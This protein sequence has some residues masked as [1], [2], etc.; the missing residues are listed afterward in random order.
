M[1]DH[2]IEFLAGW[3]NGRAAAYRAV[4][5]STLHPDYTY[6][7]PK[8]SDHVAHDVALLALT[9]PIRMNSVT[10]F[11]I[12]ARPRKGDTVGVVSYARDR[13]N[14]PALQ[15][16]CHVLGRP[17]GAL[18][19]SCDVDFGSSGAPVFVISDTGPEIVSVISAKAE[20]RGRPV[21]VGTGLEDSIFA[22]RQ[23]L[24]QDRSERT[25]HGTRIRRHSVE[26]RPT[27]GGAKFVRP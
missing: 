15:E 10:P 21:S 12:G 3:R 23:A 8:G 14:R 7:G 17:A 11:P 2:D 13:A 16:V 6:T 27:S 4:R 20:V 25:A 5:R 22:M 9:Q 18:V 19:M 1:P 24:G 26:T